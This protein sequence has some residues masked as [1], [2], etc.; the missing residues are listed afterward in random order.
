MSQAYSALFLC[1]LLTNTQVPS[2]SDS[3][4]MYIDVNT[5]LH[6]LTLLLYLLNLILRQ[7][8]YVY[9]YI[10]FLFAGEPSVFYMSLC[11]YLYVNDAGSSSYK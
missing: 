1:I 6:K 4:V 8:K 11:A 2:P 7:C 9:E 3:I 10:I 5:K